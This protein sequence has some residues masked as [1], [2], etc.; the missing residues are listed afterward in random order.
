MDK[1]NNG[2]Q[3][4]LEVPR[5]DNL[6]IISMTGHCKPLVSSLFANTNKVAL[7]AK[8]KN[9]NKAWRTQDLTK[10]CE[11]ILKCMNPL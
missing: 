3:K 1:K 2:W 10:I 9:R 8:E 5:E 11:F 7:Q 6:A 4:C